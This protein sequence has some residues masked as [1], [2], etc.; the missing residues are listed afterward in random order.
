MACDKREELAES[1]EEIR[2]TLISKDDVFQMSLK[3]AYCMLVYYY[4]EID[5]N[6]KYATIFY[7]KAG[8]MLTEDKDANSKRIL[9]YYNYGITK[10]Y[11][12]AERYLKEGLALVDSFSIGD[13]REVEKKYFHIL[14]E[15]LFTQNIK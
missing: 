3:I 5:V 11:E 13:E 9:A 12:A 6:A 15:R 4:S 10:D 8:K 2:D 7:N 1:I 14:E